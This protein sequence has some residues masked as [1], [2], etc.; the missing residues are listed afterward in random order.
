MS[1]DVGAGACSLQCI[2]HIPRKAYRWSLRGDS[3]KICFVPNVGDQELKEIFFSC[4]HNTQT[5]RAAPYLAACQRPR[6]KDERSGCGM[7]FSDR[8]PDFR[9]Q[10]LGAMSTRNCESHFCQLVFTHERSVK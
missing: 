3:K 1:G 5:A 8:A 7:R 2:A 10:S 9:S 6:K 4:P